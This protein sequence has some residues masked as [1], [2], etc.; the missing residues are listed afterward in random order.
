MSDIEKVVN[1][2]A[3]VLGK[4][5]WMDQ[6]SDQPELS[7][8]INIVS[9]LHDEGYSIVELAKGDYVEVLQD[10]RG[11]FRWRRK[12]QNHKIISTNGESHVYLPYAMKMAE[13]C[14]PG[15]PIHDLSD[16]PPH[17]HEYTERKTG[18][19]NSVTNEPITV[20]RCS[21]GRLTKKELPPRA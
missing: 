15:V 5:G 19:F 3:K 6:K 10:V 2:L 13:R 11:Q 20:L 17:I 9:S 8:A 1:V 4:R 21:C 16:Q 7:R 12:S 18:L 14:N